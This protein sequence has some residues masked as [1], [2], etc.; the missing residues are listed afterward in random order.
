MHKEPHVRTP[1]W[2]EVHFQVKMLKTDEFLE[3][4]CRK[5][6]GA[7]AQSAFPSQ[8]VQNTPCS[9]HFLRLAISL[10]NMLRKIPTP[11]TRHSF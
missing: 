10:L 9:D 11:P 6:P 5:I 2:R 1:L 8:K 4:G 3:L 7:V